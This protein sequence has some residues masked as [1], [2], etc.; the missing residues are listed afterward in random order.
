M[1][2]DVFPVVSSD[3]PLNAAFGI[4]QAANRSALVVQTGADYAFVDAAEVV[5]AMSGRQAFDL[6]LLTAD[7]PLRLLTPSDIAQ[8]SFTFLPDAAYLALDQY[9]L[10]S[11]QTYALLAVTPT[12]AIVVSRNE[13]FMP[14]QTSPKD[15]YCMHDRKP[16]PR[17]KNHG[18]CPDGHVGAVRCR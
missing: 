6:R 15:C 7:H 3:T 16:V 11:N 8:N 1:E 12:R 5:F 13:I 2:I 18:T 9:F 14:E 10:A 17:G 4:M